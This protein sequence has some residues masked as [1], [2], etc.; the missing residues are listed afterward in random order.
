MN[1]DA[2]NVEN[3]NIHQIIE[4]LTMSC[5]ASSGERSNIFRNR[6]LTLFMNERDFRERSDSAAVSESISIS[7]TNLLDTGLPVL[8]LGISPDF[9]LR[10]PLVVI[11]PFWG[12]W[13]A[14][15]HHRSPCSCL[16]QIS[17]AQRYFLT[18][19][20]GFPR[21]FRCS[22]GKHARISYTA[23]RYQI[24]HRLLILLWRFLHLHL[25]VFCST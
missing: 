18:F 9:H 11:V 19:R 17:R 14:S 25:L 22:R 20:C 24:R 23:S 10:R 5:I 12:V 21:A 16:L 15:A 3:I 2:S 6:S 13:W 4:R 8:V 1:T 7:M